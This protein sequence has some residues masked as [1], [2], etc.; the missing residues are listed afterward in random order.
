M[1]HFYVKLRKPVTSSGIASINTELLAA[2][3]QGARL[4]PC[5]ITYGDTIRFVRG[6]SYYTIGDSS[7]KSSGW[8]NNWFRR[9]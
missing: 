5:V 9:R 8:H 3:Q 4:D 2:V 7:L 6:C 1:L